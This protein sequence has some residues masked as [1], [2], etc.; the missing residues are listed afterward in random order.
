M[1]E[2]EA[3]KYIRQLL[4][5]LQH[6]HENHIVH[7]DIKPE[8]I[9]CENSRS[10]DIKLVD[11]GL[12]TKLNPQDEVRVSTA[13]PEFAAPEIA[14]HNPVGF[15]TD[16]WSVGVLAY[17]L[18]SGVS[19]FAG[20]DTMET[21]RNVSRASYDFND[22]SFR[23]VSDNAKDFISKLLIKA[24]EKRMT[25][26]E[27]L[28]HPW[29]R[30][31]ITEDQLHRIPSKRYDNVRRQMHERIGRIWERR[32]AIGH[33]CNYSSIR[34]LRRADYKI[35]SSHFD[36]R[37]AGP[38]F[39]RHPSSQTIVEGNTAQFDCR[40]IGVSEPVI[41]WVYRG[42]TLTQ[43]LKYMQRYSGHDYSLKVSRVKR[44]EDEGEYI[45]RAENSY[46]RRESSAYLTVEPIRE[47]TREPSVI[48]KKKF[49]LKEYEVILPEEVAP[50][51]SLPLR[52][53]YIQDGHTVK[54]TC[55][56]DG[57]PTPILTWFKDGHKIE[58]GGDYDIQTMLGISSLEIFSCNE[59]H[60]GKYTC[61][62]SNK[63]GE[64]ETVCKLIVEPSRVKRLLAATAA[65]RGLRSSSQFP[66][67]VSTGD[68]YRSTSTLRESSITSN[69]RLTTTTSITRT[70][71]Q[72]TN[73]RTS[74]LREVS[75]E[76]KAPELEAAID[77]PTD[78]VEGDGLSLEARFT[79]AEPRAN[80]TWSVNGEEVS[81][82]G[83]I[84]IRTS[85]N[86]TRSTLRITDLTSDDSGSYECKAS[87]SA[88]S[89][90]TRTN[91]RVQR[92]PKPFT[93]DVN[94]FSSKNDVAFTKHAQEFEPF[95]NNLVENGESEA[96]LPD[97]FDQEQD[98][99]NGE[100]MDVQRDFKPEVPVLIRQLQGQIVD[101]GVDSVTFS[102]EFKNA[103]GVGWSFNG[104]A[105][106]PDDKYDITMD[107]SE[108]ILTVKD[109]GLEDSGVYVCY[110][111]NTD[112]R[113]TTVGYLSV[114]D[115]SNPLPGPQ[116]LTFP[117]SVMTTA[118]RPIELECSFTSPVTTL[119]LCQNELEME[120]AKS[121]ISE[122]GL[123]AKISLAGN[124]LIPA[125]SGKYAI[126]AQDDEGHHC[127]WWIDIQVKAATKS[128]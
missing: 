29:L 94:S 122:N 31:P 24:P 106:A 89:A 111:V 61:L 70:S 13:T 90:K 72:S 21:L 98:H 62:A 69:G 120:E 33:I 15:Y 100:T 117:R 20:A 8:N 66:Y 4:E 43:S 40:V 121:V 52:N 36:H 28:D 85:S 60:S 53:R 25:V 65:G 118:D 104:K 74:G 45:V 114:R 56:A 47:I 78:L 1:N 91:L 12:S 34:R 92:K 101:L 64:D 95:D 73:R 58:R 3:I 57:N 41:T 42:V 125:D 39:V 102:C 96:A 103:T 2:G 32:P 79:E 109:V 26:F 87:N 81:S 116:F 67:S 54:L 71:Y 99:I 83:H 119:M 113:V 7:L 14:D 59:G 46:G 97:E 84:S 76:Q 108:V 77:A 18:L 23:D 5:G 123:S 11:F 107:G 124:E 75:P 55:T 27:A 50:R 110:A 49:V 115:P 16:M 6:M 44:P 80:I 82:D 35:Y 127:E 88:G 93:E 9:M 48:P 10:T 86:G 105:L 51:F 63:L 22:D 17:I 128:D 30:T 126:I 112:G 68:S 37:E 19:P 38:R